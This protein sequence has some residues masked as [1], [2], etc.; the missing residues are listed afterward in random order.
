MIFEKVAALYGQRN[1]STANNQPV[2]RCPG[3]GLCA[4][5]SGA[6]GKTFQERVD[7]AVPGCPRCQGRGPLPPQALT[8]ENG[9]KDLMS[10]E[11]IDYSFRVI[12]SLVDDYHAGILNADDL[13]AISSDLFEC[14]KFWIKAERVF[15]RDVGNHITAFIKSFAKK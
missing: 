14:Y 8:K 10:Q 12:E 5:F 13:K 7:N 3:D 9:S 15:D 11:E 2:F 1:T 6:A 4:R